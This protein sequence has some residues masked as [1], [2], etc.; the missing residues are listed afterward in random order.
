MD[1]W[2][3]RGGDRAAAV[4]ERLKYRGGRLDDEVLFELVALGDVVAG[5]LV[6]DGAM[7]DR[8][9]PLGEP[10]NNRQVLLDKEDR[11]PELVVDL[12]EILGDRLIMDRKP[13]RRLSPEVTLAIA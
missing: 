2:L 1:G 11:R 10:L 9:T 4:A 3:T 12:F 6:D 8:I 5:D 13:P 7:V